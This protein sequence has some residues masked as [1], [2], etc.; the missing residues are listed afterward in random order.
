[1]SYITAAFEGSLKLQMRIAYSSSL[2]QYI[3]YADP[4]YSEGDNKWMICKMTYDSGSL[5]TKRVFA[6]G[7]NAFDKNW[8]DRAGY[9]YA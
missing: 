2:A 7:S 8:T 9:E 4:G 5:M 1:M 6:G 3:G